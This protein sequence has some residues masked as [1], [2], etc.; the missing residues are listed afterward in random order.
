MFSN[1]SERRK[2]KSWV[3]N[4]Y[5]A[6]WK[7]VI[8]LLGGWVE[9]GRLQKVFSLW[10][11]V[12]DGKVKIRQWLIK[13]NGQQKKTKYFQIVTRCRMGSPEVN[14]GSGGQSLPHQQRWHSITLRWRCSS[15]FKHI[16]LY[17]RTSPLLPLVNFQD[18][19][20]KFKW[21]LK[22]FRKILHIK[23]TDNQSMKALHQ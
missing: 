4:K 16:F 21:F 3:R 20:T 15:F 12:W 9:Y 8:I 11:Q 7:S 6:N 23:N 5:F 17:F 10:E 18:F 2:A 19:K 1:Q 14:G 13:I 22:T